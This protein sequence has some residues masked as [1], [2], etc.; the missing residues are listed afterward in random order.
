MPRYLDVLTGVPSTLAYGLREKLKEGYGGGD[1]RADLMAGLVVGVVA[2]PLSMALAI[3]SGVAPQHGLYTA[4]IA[5]V[6]C[7]LLGGTRCQ[8]TGPTAAFVVILVPIVVK[9]GLGGLLVAGLMAGVILIA[10]GALKLGN[11]IQYIPHP[12]TTGF[13]AGIA[14]VIGTIQLKDFFGLSFSA[15]ESYVERWRLMFHARGTVSGWELGVGVVTLAMLLVIPRLQKRVPA[16]LIALVLA[17]VGAAAAAH[18]IPGFHVATIGSRFSSLVSGHVV[19]GIPPLPPLPLNPFAMPGAG[20]AP[21][22]FSFTL[23]QALLGPAFVIAMLG[24]IES[25]LAAVVSDGMSGTRHDPNAELMALGIANVVCPLFG[26]IAATGALART[27]TNIRAGARSPFAA[28]IHSVF[29]LLC[30]VALAP[31]VAYLPMAALAALL[32]TV[33]RNM[34]EARHFI[35]ILRVAP[36]SDAL[37]LLTCFSLTVV[38]DMVI[39]VSVGVVLAALLFM[40]RMAELSE[41]KLDVGTMQRLDLPPGVK[42]YEIAGPLFFG[43]AQRAM[44]AFD[45]ISG[46]KDA[47]QPQAVILFLGQV[48]AIDATGLVALET[49]ID[50]LKR[51]GNKVILAGMRPQ[52]AEVVARAG[53][54]PERGH[55]AIAPD[56]DAALSLAMI[57]SLRVV[58]SANVPA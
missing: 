25:L 4:I 3:A 33:A 47:G 14:V 16:P 15:P 54:A 49:S 1:F 41:T 56:L 26:G 43:A 9:F 57:H 58:P 32:L 17:S 30:T 8:V 45:N 29:V 24:A 28:V 51:S 35:H 37:V 5:G 48:P 18:F 12:V 7:A 39:A 31:L 2:L 55:L 34:A 27:A 23:V 40:R 36:R 50:K 38:F 10:M 6:V 22:H 44:S 20:G 13:T 52:V 11:L 42:L 46:T 53:I 19:P 21:M